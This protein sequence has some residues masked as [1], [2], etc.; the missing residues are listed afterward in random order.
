MGYY[1]CVEVVVVLFDDLHN[2]VSCLDIHIC[3]IDQ[4][5]QLVKFV[6]DLTFKNSLGRNC[7]SITADEICLT[8]ITEV[9]IVL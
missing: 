1:E 4:F 2:V 7:K 9:G 5:I 6:P 8:F 3:G